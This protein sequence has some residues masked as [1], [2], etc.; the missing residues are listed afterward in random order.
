MSAQSGSAGKPAR[1]SGVS[2]S[3]KNGG[4]GKPAVSGTV[5]TPNSPAALER[6]IDERRQHLAATIDELTFRAK[7]KEIA[8]RGVAGLRARVQR[9][10]HTPEGELRTER[11]A[12][13][14]GA[15]AVLAG[16]LVYLRRRRR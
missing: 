2:R 4:K 11:L 15:V 5:V 14:G 8:R 6:A 7:P 16:L 3:G 12:A 13:A 1:K 9:V 10:T